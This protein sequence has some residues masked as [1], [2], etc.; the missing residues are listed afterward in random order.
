MSSNLPLV[1]FLTLLPFVGAIAVLLLGRS[2]ARLTAA[3][4]ATVAVAYTG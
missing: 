4:F 2:V 3:T 1:S